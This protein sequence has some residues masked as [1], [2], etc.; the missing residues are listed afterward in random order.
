MLGCGARLRRARLLGHA[1]RRAPAAAGASAKTT[2]DCPSMVWK[3]GVSPSPVAAICSVRSS[4]SSASGAASSGGASCPAS[5][6]SMSCCSMA[7]GGGATAA[8][9][10]APDA[11]RHGSA[12]AAAGA[13]GGGAGL[14]AAGLAVSSSAMMRR[15]EA[16]ISS[17][18]GSC[19]FA[20][21][22]IAESLQCQ[23]RQSPRDARGIE[24]PQRITRSLDIYSDRRQVWHGVF[25]TPTQPCG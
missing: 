21:W 3:L 9:T 24:R 18:D 6:A 25:R 22:L 23:S 17:I 5:I 19:A 2:S 15:M 20:G 11:R 1:R 8:A 13:A 4:T 16:R 7:G 12:A 14:A 10:A